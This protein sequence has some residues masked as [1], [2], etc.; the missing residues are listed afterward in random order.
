ME[1][2]KVAIPRKLKKPAISVIVVRNI[3]EDCAGSCPVTVNIIG[4]TAPATPAITMDRIIDMKIIKVS[5]L[6][7]LQK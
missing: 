7:S 4:I 6:E 1:I 3:V 2:N 5:P